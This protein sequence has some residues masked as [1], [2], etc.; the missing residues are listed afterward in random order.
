MPLTPNIPAKTKIEL[1]KSSTSTGPM[2]AAEMM[3][4]DPVK[5]NYISIE[6]IATLIVLYPSVIHPGGTYTTYPIINVKR[7]YCTP[8]PPSSIILPIGVPHFNLL[9]RYPSI[10]SNHENHYIEKA[11]KKNNHLG[12]SAP[13][14]YEFPPY[15]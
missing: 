10:I 6:N 4:N 2:S 3:F 5:I 15:I 13:L 11:P 14:E 1:K 8:S 12:S 7:V 9:A